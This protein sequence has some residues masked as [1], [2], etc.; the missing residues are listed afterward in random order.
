M[1]S[2]FFIVG[3]GRS[4]SSLLSAILQQA[5]ANFGLPTLKEWDRDHGA[6]EHP[7]LDKMNS[8]HKWQQMIAQK[9]PSKKGAGFCKRSRFKI[10]NAMMQKADFFNIHGWEYVVSEAN[11][12]GYK[13]KIIIS[14][15]NFDDYAISL[16]L[17]KGDNYTHKQLSDLYFNFNAESLMLLSSFGGCAISYEELVDNKEQS[18]ATCLAR[19]TGLAESDLLR[20]RD[21]LAVAPRKRVG[22]LSLPKDERIESILLQLQE[23]KGKVIQE[24]F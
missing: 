14:Y 6:L 8:W 4:G 11:E 18:W 24:S 3:T 17:K 2:K 1:K 21:E 13:P 7:D 16:Y 5:G 15:R 9:M 10:L 12:L 20:T 19:I 22:S 23:L